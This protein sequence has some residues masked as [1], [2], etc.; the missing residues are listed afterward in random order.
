MMKKLVDRLLN[1]AVV[2]NN[3]IVKVDHFINHQLDTKL[4]DEIGEAFSDEFPQ[5]TKILTIESSGIAYGVSTALHLN[6]V[7]VVFARKEKS[8]IISDKVYH[9]EAFSFTKQKTS[10]IT[11]SKDFLSKDDKVLIIDDFLATGSALKALVAICK[12]AG[13]TVEGIGIVIEKSFLNA[14]DLF[15]EEDFKI[16][17]LANIT[18]IK[19]NTLTIKKDQ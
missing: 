13:A 3:S 7:P 9:S 15:K 14:R 11:V 6:Y 8:S 12:Q 4:I 19:N 2:I 17:S 10:T 16:L 18:E 5:T 1:D